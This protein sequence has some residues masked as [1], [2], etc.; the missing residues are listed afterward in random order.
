[1]PDMTS[2]TQGGILVPEV[3]SY[4]ER[5]FPAS[6]GV[7]AEMEAL[8]LETGFPIVGRQVGRLFWQLACLKGAQTVFDMGS[9]FGYSTA[10]FALAVG[11][12][13]RVVYTDTSPDNCERAREFLGR[14][15]LNDRVEYHVGEAVAALERLG[16]QYDLVM[17]D[18][19]KTQYPRAFEIASQRVIPGGMLLAD[20][21]LWK[22]KV[23]REA[24]NDEATQAIREYNRLIF[25]HPDFMSTVVPLRDGISLSFRMR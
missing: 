23:A 2:T 21:T 12:R 11:E 14:M 16:G 20:N 19:E 24:E 3:E 18:V 9:G 5:L 4:L 10:W 17:V 1:M 15:G 6:P 25:E 22:G 13:G 8:A 7:L